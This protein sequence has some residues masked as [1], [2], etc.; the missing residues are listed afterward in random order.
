[1]VQIH[2]QFYRI[3]NNLKDKPL[4]VSIMSFLQRFK[5]DWELTFIMGGTILW[6]EI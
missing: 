4:V 3:Y 2:C 6:P 1:M 5:V